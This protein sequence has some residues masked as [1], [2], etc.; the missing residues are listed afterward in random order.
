MEME[1]E[2]KEESEEEGEEEEEEPT[3]RLIF[4]TGPDKRKSFDISGPCKVVKSA[5]K[6]GRG[7][8]VTLSDPEVSSS[9]ASLSLKVTKSRGKVASICVIVKVKYHHFFVYLTKPWL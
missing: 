2:E 4:E 3:L 1:E 7:E 5:P 6:R 9:H 8:N